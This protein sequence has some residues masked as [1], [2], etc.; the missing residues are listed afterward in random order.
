MLNSA[1][2]HVKTLI[3][4]FPAISF[5]GTQKISNYNKKFY[6]FFHN[7]VLFTDLISVLLPLLE[8]INLPQ[9]KRTFCTLNYLKKKDNHK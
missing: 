9:G 3:S 4:C 7:L 8:K 1:K 2:L 6:L 5:S